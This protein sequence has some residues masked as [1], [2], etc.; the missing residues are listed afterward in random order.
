MY[1]FVWP[2]S[3]STWNSLGV[4]D[5]SN[6]EQSQHCQEFQF[7]WYIPGI[8]ISSVL[9]PRYLKPDPEKRSKFKTAIKK[10]TLNPEY[11][12]VREICFCSV[13]KCKIFYFS[14]YIYQFE[15]D[16]KDIKF[17]YD[18]NLYMTLSIMNQPRKPWRL[19][20]GIGILGK[21]M[22]SSVSSGYSSF[23]EIV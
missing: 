13:S 2:N 10:K 5:K 23:A 22:I 7:Y 18:R 11:N 9:L 15:L 6:Y 14:N 1:H 17:S 16:I 4:R 12:E 20:Y 3:N 21:L 19:Q 8:L